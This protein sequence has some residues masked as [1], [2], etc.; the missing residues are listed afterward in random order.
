MKIIC[1]S[2]PGGWQSCVDGTG[3]LF[4]PTYNKIQDLWAWQRMNLYGTNMTM[5]DLPTSL[6]V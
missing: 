1:K 2:V 6:G 3:Y 4:G 5:A